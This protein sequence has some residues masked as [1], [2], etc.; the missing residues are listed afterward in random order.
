MRFLIKLVVKILLSVFPYKLKVRKN[1]LFNS[2]YTLWISNF[3]GRL[4]RG[5]CICRGC[6][7]QGGGEKSIKIGENTS[8]GKDCILGCWKYYQG[9]EYF[10][11]I[12]I[13]NNCNIGEYNHISACHKII[14]GDGVLT[15][16]YVYISDNNHGETDVNTLKSPPIKRDLNVRGEV[17]IGDN[18]WIGD[19]VSILSGVTIG[20]G[21]I[22]ASN[23]VVTKDVP[24]YSVVG[25]VPARVI[26]VFDNIN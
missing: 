19:K 14:I 12:T 24:P 3:L 13:G 23:A 1:N 22:I 11:S 15:G 25:G 18:V 21:A 4:G 10:P 7:L 2:V 17:K 9:K 5:S 6:D 26:K 16:R 20:E 8:V